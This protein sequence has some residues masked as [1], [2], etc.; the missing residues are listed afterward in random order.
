MNI[1]KL[2]KAHKLKTTKPRKAILEVL[3]HS[4]RPLTLETLHE[5]ASSSLP[6]DPVTVYRTIMTLK[7]AGLICQSDLG[8]GHAHYELSLDGHHHHI[9]C[10]NCGKTSAVHV[11]LP[12]SFSKKILSKARGFKSVNDHV[13]ELFGLCTACSKKSLN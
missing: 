12:S 2:L 13:L 10:T 8:H 5:K 9:V 6:V 4:S 1:E 3:S 7:E 11:C